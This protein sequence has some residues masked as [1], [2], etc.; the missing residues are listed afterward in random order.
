[1]HD[2][3]TADFSGSPPWSEAPELM[4]ISSF[5][6]RALFLLAAISTLAA[7]A[8]AQ[9][10]Q[11]SPIQ[12]DEVVRINTALVQTDV[13]VFDKRGSFVE[14]LKREQFLLKVDGKP[15]LISFFETVKAGSYSEEAQLAA[16]RG[17]AKTDK[18]AGTPVPLDRGRMM[19]FFVDDF[20]LAAGNLVR[21][22]ESLTRFINRTM[23][24]NDE[25]EILTAS[26]QAGFLEQLTD[27]KAVLRA[28]VE[29]L[30]LH[31]R[32]V[33][34]LD[35]P[36]MSEYQA[37][38]IARND[39]D[40]LDYFID[41]LLKQLSG[42][43]REVA[44]EMIRQR[45]L[46][47]LQQSGMINT[48]TL[49]SLE[50]D[51]KSMARLPGRKLLIFMSDGFL[52]DLRNSDAFDRLRRVTSAAAAAGV[53]IYSID[54]RGLV[55]SLTDASEPVPFDPTGR[56]ARASGGELSATQDGLNALAHDTGGR[57]FFN[58]NALGAAVTTAVKESSV[59]YLL[60]WRPEN[61]KQSS[62][63]FRQI[64]VSIVGRPELLVRFRR[65]FGEPNATESVAQSK[66]QPPPT[67]RTPIQD[68]R[69]VLTANYPVSKLPVS[70]T[71]NFL[72]V[73]QSGL[74][75]A[76]S[77]KV[78][79]GRVVLEPIGGLPTAYIDIEGAI[80][81]ESGKSVGTF[82]NRFT[83][84][85]RSLDA[86]TPPESLSYNHFSAIKPGI[87]QVRVAVRDAKEG[88]LGSAFQWIEIPNLDSKTL[89]LSTLI[90]AERESTADNSP[91]IDPAKT[92]K[93]QS[94][95]GQLRLNVDHRFA[96]TS[97]LRFLMFVYNALATSPVLSNS[98]SP[99]GGNG[100]IIPANSTVVA[101][102]LA[103]QV[104]VF[105]DN[106][107]VITDPLHKIPVEGVDFTRVPYAAEL[108]L[109]SLPP[110]RYVLQVTVID[111]FAKA[112][113]S[114]R[115]SFEVD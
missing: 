53:V 8:V 35:S 97:R 87:Y 56:L 37:L 69:S 36:R 110:G 98:P 64:E 66:R 20:H 4:R 95:F 44:G 113:A 60:A 49:A 6:T 88:R 77:L 65:G 94:L 13:T 72:N 1:M 83:I 32:T 82:D 106:E 104:Q 34:D 22:R 79:T 7:V 91:L 27:N 61:E 73:P 100:A 52:L 47:M 99:N 51:V 23:G 112:S 3:I 92:G 26:G 29:R 108:T 39:N 59:Y 102:D 17:G 10:P 11:S 81:D 55:A 16:A 74:L 19:F 28:A 111:R 85:A 33:R 105:R 58:T 103:V 50:S 114:Q 67:A 12:S 24:Q 45:A 90:A 68:L 96:R 86:K 42:L 46:S 84:K 41:E 93:P 31:Q 48:R 9:Q 15:R 2:I 30:T 63:R 43:P 101:P 109:S 14:D 70:M 18:T 54:S 5:P 62:P 21:V 25:A 107:P 89:A 71:L 75:L 57:A 115:F 38:Q 40:V 78:T 76:M 80:F